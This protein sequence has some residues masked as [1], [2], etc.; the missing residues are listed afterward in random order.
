MADLN[1]AKFD[2]A[3]DIHTELPSEVGL[4]VHPAIALIIARME[5]NPEQFY[6]WKPASTGSV[7][8]AHPINASVAQIVEGT[9]G[10]WNRKEKRLY[11]LAL[12]KVRLQEAHERLMAA[13]LK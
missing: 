4:D 12:R 10:T 3:Q 5:S 6:K 13:I 8:N 11:N 9:K 7:P 2:T 1:A